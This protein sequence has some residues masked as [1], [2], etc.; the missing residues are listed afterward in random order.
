[1]TAVERAS[2]LNKFFFFPSFSLRFYSAPF[3]SCVIVVV[4]KCV[5]QVPG[6]LQQLFRHLPL[7]LSLRYSFI[8]FADH[9]LRARVY[10]MRAICGNIV[11][12]F[13]NFSVSFFIV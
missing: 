12:T 3:A 6:S 5:I 10:V 8:L 9:L 11:R 2:S 1:M 13:L 7:I 4:Q